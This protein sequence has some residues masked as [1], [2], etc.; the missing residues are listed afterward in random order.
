MKLLCKLFGHKYIRRNWIDLPSNKHYSEACKHC[1]CGGAS[2]D[3]SHLIEV[4]TKDNTW[5]IRTAGGGGGGI[6]K[7]L[8]LTGSVLE[9]GWLE[10]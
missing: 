4:T 6:S 8:K 1:G 5:E 7:D 3:F 10:K 2:A 9:N